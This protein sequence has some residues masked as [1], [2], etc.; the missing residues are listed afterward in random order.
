MN[1]F[2]GLFSIFSFLNIGQ[3]G[4]GIAFYV[5]DLLIPEITLKRGETYTFII[6][7]GGD[8]SKT[9]DYHPVYISDDPTG[10][11]VNK[12]AQQKQVCTI[13]GW[14]SGLTVVLLCEDAC[15]C[16]YFL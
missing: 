5:N 12:N 9:A 11:Y 4:W 1:L 6:E 14:F 7:T 13:V 10:G 15:K 8:S 16:C 2:I 3:V